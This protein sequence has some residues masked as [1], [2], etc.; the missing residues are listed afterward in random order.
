[1]SFKPRAQMLSGQGH[2]RSASR[3]VCCHRHCFAASRM[4]HDTAGSLPGC[5]IHVPILIVA[6]R[7]MT[8]GDRGVRELTSSVDKSCSMSPVPLAAMVA[9][10]YSFSLTSTEN[11]VQTME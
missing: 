3:R 11:Y 7:E 9:I 1:M 5:H 4:E 6:W 2:E 8:C 10:S